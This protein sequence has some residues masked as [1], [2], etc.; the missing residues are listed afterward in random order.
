M[1][2]FTLLSTIAF[3]IQVVSYCTSVRLQKTEILVGYKKKAKDKNSKLRFSHVYL[4][5]TSKEHAMPC[6]HAHS[7]EGTL[8]ACPLD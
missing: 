1:N 2:R 5:E 7:L 8:W 6:V 3:M 4:C